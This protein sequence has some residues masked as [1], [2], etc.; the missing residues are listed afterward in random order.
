MEKALLKQLRERFG[1][2][3]R[4]AVLLP[5]GV[6]RVGMLHFRLDDAGVLRVWA[7]PHEGWMVAR[8]LAQLSDVL[9]GATSLTPP[10]R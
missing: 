2:K 9:V 4:H 3:A 5:G 10:E 7:G 1:V 8:N 6:A